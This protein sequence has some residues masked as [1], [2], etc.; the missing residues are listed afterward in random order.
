MFDVGDGPIKIDFIVHD[1]F[2]SVVL[3]L[4]IFLGWVVSFLPSCRLL[5]FSILNLLLID[6]DG[7][8]VV[9][10]GFIIPSQH[11]FS[12]SLGEVVFDHMIITKL[13]C[14]PDILE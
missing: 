11:E 4:S 12:V 1:L 3:L 10:D 9:L 13:K 6:N 7:V 5:P 8:G 2:L 14:F